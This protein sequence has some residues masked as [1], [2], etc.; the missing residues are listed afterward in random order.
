[1]KKTNFAKRLQDVAQEAQA[2]IEKSIKKGQYIRLFTEQEAEENDSIIY[3]MPNV[4]CVDKYG[5][6]DEYG[7]IAVS[8]VSKE[9]IIILEGKGERTGEKMEIPLSEIGDDFQLSDSDLCFLADELSK[10]I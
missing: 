8:K 7:V 2:F 1:M 6:Y 5:S 10:L 4:S 3:E 9:V